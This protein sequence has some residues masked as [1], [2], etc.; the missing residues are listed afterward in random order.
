MTI[1]KNHYYKIAI[2]S[3]I[4]LFTAAASVIFFPTVLSLTAQRNK[5]LHVVL[6]IRLPQVLIAL[7]AGSCLGLAGALMQTILGNSLASPFT[8][9]ISSAAAFGASVAIALGIHE[10]GIRFGTSASAFVFAVASILLLLLILSMAGISQRNIILIGMAVNFFFTAANT[11]LKYYAP[12]DAV[13]Q[14]T[15][16]SIG[17]LTNA[18]LTD[19]GVLFSIFVVS[20]A[21]SLLYSK[22]FGLIQQGERAAIMQGVNVNAERILFL[23]ICSLLA[24]FSVVIV[25][26]IGFIGL[27]SPHAA[28]LL[29]FKAPKELLLS[30]TIIG[31]LF[32]VFSDIIAKSIL[33]PAVLPVGSVTSF[34]GIPALLMLLFIM[35]GK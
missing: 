9:G 35:K 16:W 12:P 26:I 31:A 5:L 8:L 11:V 32:L 1:G 29:N 17:S 28:R 15:F 2:L 14:I 21:I 33:Y 19:S 24:A 27:V 25:G 10:S 34:L 20:L 7:T 22:D 6:K 18:T 23:L 4:L 13:Y 30:S 3:I